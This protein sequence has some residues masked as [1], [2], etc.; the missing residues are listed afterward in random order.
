MLASSQLLPSSE[1]DRYFDYCLEPYR[2]RRPWQGKLRSENLL[3]SSLC[4]GGGYDA[5]REPVEAIQA[6]VGR[7]LTVW[8]VKW[9][10]ERL[11]WELY[12]YDPQKESP[13]ATITSLTEALSPWIRVVPRIRESIP[14]MMVSFDLTA[15]AAGG[16][17]DEFN[18]YLAGEDAHA[19]RSY[20]VRADAIQLENT[21]K[22]MAP[23]PE[24]DEVLSLIQA[25]LYVDFSDPRTLSK[26][27]I[28]EL[29]ACKKVCVAKKRYCD[30]IYYSGIDVGQLQWFLKRFDYPEAITG[31][32]SQHRASFEHLYFDVGI[33]YLHDE[34]GELVYRKTSY[35]GTV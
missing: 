34:K 9:D 27:L 13:E 33:D 20:E 28:P 7:D 31:F 11:W 25:S 2:P 24:I 6:H 14:Y 3:W 29:F 18:L 35:Y 22:F 12:F 15:A 5:L 23:K 8:G 26:V 16:T 30:A 19:G 21:Y 1:H 4:T 17:V 10:G 32:V